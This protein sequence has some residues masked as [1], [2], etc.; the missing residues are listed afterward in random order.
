VSACELAVDST[1]DIFATQPFGG[2]VNKYDSAGD[3]QYALDSN[4][5][6]G[7]A[8][9]PASGDVYVAESSSVVQFDA[10]NS[11][12]PSVLGSFATGSVATPSGVAVR[13]ST[14]EAFVSDS[15]A[16]HVAIFGAGVAA[17]DA[18]TG[19][20][21]GV[22]DTKATVVGGVNPEGTATEWQFQYGTDTSYG[23]SAPAS[24]QS[25][26]S[27]SSEV[28]VSTELSGLTAGTTYHYR[29]VA[30]GA[31]GNTYGADQS[32][33]TQA[34]PTVDSQ[35]AEPVGKVT[36]TLNAQVN[37]FGAETTYHFEYGTSESYGTSTVGA[38]I[39]AGFGDQPA[40]AEIAGLQANTTY[41][42][43]VVATN[44]LG[45]PVDGSDQ[46]FTTS[47]ALRV[48]HMFVSAVTSSEATLNAEVNPLGDATTYHFEYGPSESYGT[49]VPVPEASA[50][51]GGKDVTVSQTVSALAADTQLHYRIVATNA[52]GTITSEDHIFKTFPVHVAETDS[53]PNAA[54][55]KQQ[56]SAFLPDCRAYEMVSPPDKNGSNVLLTS[57]RTRV[58]EN[59]DAFGFAS[60]AGFGDAREVA[61]ASDYVSVRS[62]SADPG[63]S[64]W[65][66][67]GITPVQRSLSLIDTVS[68]QEP[69]YTGPYSPD[70]STGVFFGV[71]P[72][73][74][75]P[76]VAGV[77]N[78]YRRTDVLAPGGGAYQLITAC[79]LCAASGTPLPPLSGDSISRNRQ[80]PVLAGVSPDLGEVVFESRLN[81][82]AD[83]PAQ[84]AFCNLTRFPFSFACG[85]RLYEWDKGTVRLAGILPDGSAADAAFAGEGANLFNLTPDVVSDGS[86]GHSRVFFT[87]P[88]DASGN[89]LAQQNSLGGSFSVNGS[90]SGNLFMRV[91]HAVTEQLNLSERM[92]PDAF[93]P[94]TF[95]DASKDGTRIFFMSGQALTD[96]APADG[97]QKI[98]LYE[99]TKPGSDPHNLTLVNPDAEPGDGTNNAIGEVGLSNDGHYFY[100]M[101]SGEL[102]SGG[103]LGGDWIYLWHDGQL[104]RVGPAPPSGDAEREDL[105]T[106]IT[107]NL[108]PRQSRVSAD[109]HVL[110]FSTISGD[111]LTGYDHGRCNTGIGFGCRELYVY[112]TDTGRAACV[113]CNP[114]G[115]PAVGMATIFLGD[116]TIGGTRADPPNSEPLTADGSKVFFSSPDA[117]VPGDTNGRYDVY[118][119]DVRTGTVLLLTSGTSASDSY[120]IN[121]DADGRNVFVITRQQLVGWDGDVNYDMYDVRVDGGFPEPPPRPAPCA[122]DACQGPLGGA[123]GAATFASG[124]ITTAGNLAAPVTRPL[125]G[126]QKLSRALRA[127]RKRPKWSRRKCES[128]ARRRYAGKASKGGRSK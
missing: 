105:A 7:V 34:P 32:F 76:M 109:G 119:Y 126:A 19:A 14:N 75:D 90:S 26:G 66:T 93:A 40:S 127:C 20:S 67:H 121:A 52:H 117:L 64:G 3:L 51:S 92:T 114:S 107:W 12:A 122:G 13:G 17:P 83:A 103:P 49:S 72:L 1:G 21:S 55:R 91:D 31:N 62:S 85:E 111:G 99:A 27:G 116:N 30:I 89:T 60:L 71:S 98:Y 81:L 58:A 100:F 73:T 9:D 59:G 15:S 46:T 61:V 23:S 82:T 77:S 115:A 110:L 78:L 128:Q 118:E 80:R 57:E 25:A 36:A 41:H 47:V 95:L 113:S 42:Y 87:Q 70:M 97:T 106:G 10:S 50:G 39:P 124:T 8:V 18:T 125:T 33:T 68:G 108:R 22:T 86:D 120:F 96:D 94:A 56:G 38:S 104:T 43:R 54:I 24:P 112:S 102:V 88:T 53:C 5:A 29:L 44:S 69:L 79:P 101:Q 37:P 4:N 84:P 74:S 65:A 48:G 6:T 28:P 35:S 11:I 45:G 16:G 123:P 2:P 63:S